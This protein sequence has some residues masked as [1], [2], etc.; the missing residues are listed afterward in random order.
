MSI[1]NL[2]GRARID[3]PK[4][5]LHPRATFM[6]GDASLIPEFDIDARDEKGDPLPVHV[7]VFTDPDGERHAFAFSEDGKAAFLRAGTGGIILDGKMPPTV[8]S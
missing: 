1:E 5:V 6:W 4:F 2:I 3:Q 7:V 8:P